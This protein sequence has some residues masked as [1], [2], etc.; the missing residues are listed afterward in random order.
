MADHTI[1]G[2]MQRE[3]DG[4]N[5]AADTARLQDILAR[6]AA[7]RARYEELAAL[8]AA[9]SR[10]APVPPPPGLK[11][12]ILAALP[13]GRYPAAA[14][15]WPWTFIPLRPAVQLG[16]ALALGLALGFV[17]SLLVTGGPSA[18]V[19]LDAVAGT[20][21]DPS[22]RGFR[23]VAEAEVA[24]PALGGR[25]RLSRSP[26]YLAV[27]LELQADA[28]ATVRLSGAA[29]T[30][31]SVGVVRA[32]GEVAARWTGEALVLEFAGPCRCVCFFAP[33]DGAAAGVRLSASAGN[34]EW[35]TTL[36]P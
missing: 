33:A 27:G 5:S 22:A 13:A 23:P 4:A 7:A 28:P 16:L 1:D 11:E 12:D 35:I 29:G 19:G 18:E 32:A 24:L 8:A 9:L 2:L 36:A 31:R 34:R 10:V 30:L 25:V 26:A 17:A 6:D 14:R 15:G 20:L 3:I 21:L